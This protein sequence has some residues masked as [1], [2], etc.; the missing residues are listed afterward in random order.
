MNNRIE[1]PIF[2]IGPGR[3]G[4]TLLLKLL[5]EHPEL[6][7][8][9]GWTNRFPDWPALAIFSRI[10]DFPLLRA[11]ERPSRYW[12]L[13][14]ETYRIWDRCFPGFSNASDEWGAGQVTRHGARLLEN[15]IAAHLKWQVKP[16]F[17]TKYT[18]WPRIEFIRR[19]FPDAI[20]VYIVRD[21]RANAYS[22]LKSG[23]W[24]GST[25]SLPRH[26]KIDF[27]CDRYLSFHHA[28][29]RYDRSHDF[30][31]VKY[32]SLVRD[33]HAQLQRVEKYCCLNPS[34]AY[35]RKIRKW[36]IRSGANLDW[37]RKLSVDEQK[38]LEKRLVEPLLTYGY[39]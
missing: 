39:R 7:W 21:P 37:R 25:R 11:A 14:G 16:R 9:S 10:N 22:Y 13:P 26:E 2:I 4:S 33:V 15:R 3:S 35:A 28:L 12:P 34:P 19:I 36:K 38:H 24:Q 20:F 1:R 23:W 6:A 27:Y 31:L 29:K 5:G 18:G 8:F 17:I 32:E 30:M